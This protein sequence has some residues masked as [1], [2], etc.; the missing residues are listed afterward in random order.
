MEYTKVKNWNGKPLKGVWE[1]CYKIDGVR[2]LRDADGNPVSR[3]GKP[4][5]GLQNVPK[6]ITDA[7]V[8]LGDWGSSVSAVRT[9]NAPAVDD[10]NIY[11]LFPKMDKRLLIEIE[12][13]LTP[14]LIENCLRYVVGK[15][16]EGLI[17]REVYGK[18]RVLRVKP[19]ETYDEVVIGYEEGKGKHAGRM[20]ALVTARGKVGTGFTDAERVDYHNRF[21]Q[22][23][24]IGAVTIEVECMELTDDGLFRHPRYLRERFDK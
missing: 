8:F 24:L 15:G 22:G 7:E 2:M 4:L 23:M 3:A 21:V 19:K 12:A 17:L 11:P 13:D 9:M 10:I 20:G 14:E 6:H 18:R 5:Y 1:I 16:Y